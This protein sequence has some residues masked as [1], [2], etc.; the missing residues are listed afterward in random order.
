MAHRTLARRA[1]HEDVIKGSRF[2]AVVAPLAAPDE[3]EALVAAVRAAHPEAGHV[4]W[5]TLWGDAR[6][7]SDDGEPG[8]TAG[9][10]MLEVLE[11]RGLDRAAAAVARRFG[12]VK[13]GAGGLARAY[14][15]SVA[16]AV[17]A[18]GVAF[19]PDR[20]A[21]RVEAPFAAADALLRALQARADVVVAAPDYGPDGVVLTGTV[22][23]E[24]EEELATLVADL[25]RGRGRWWA[26]PLDT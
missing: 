20:D 13:L 4:A 23:R 1:E 21:Y 6:R 7:W 9:R 16:K 25:T 15:G 8:G 5:A 17:D 19:V 12:G 10:P 14:G 2:F 11:K 24:A 26:D 18:A 3:A 22:L